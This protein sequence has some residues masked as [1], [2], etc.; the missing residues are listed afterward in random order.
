MTR[1]S[2]GLAVIVSLALAPALMAADD[3]EPGDTSKREAQ[4]YFHSKSLETD[5]EDLRSWLSCLEECCNR[6]NK[7]CEVG[8][9]ILAWL[10]GIR[11]HELPNFIVYLKAPQNDG[12]GSLMAVPPSLIWRK[13]NTP[14]VRGADQIWVLVFSD[15]DPKIELDV[16]LVTLFE[17]T[18]NPFSGLLAALKVAPGTSVPEP[19]RP[20]KTEIKTWT[21]LGP[22]EGDSV[23]YLGTAR[24]PV[25][26]DSVNFL[27][28]VPSAETESNDELARPWPWPEDAE[29]TLVVRPKLPSST[30][31]D[32]NQETKAGGAQSEESLKTDLRLVSGHF[33]NSSASL[34]AFSVGLIGTLNAED[35]ALAEETHFNGYAL[36]K[37]Y[38]RRPRIK[39][40]LEEGRVSLRTRPSLGLVLGTG[41]DDLFEEV[42]VG[43][44]IGH[45]LGRTGVVLGANRIPRVETVDHEW[46]PFVGLE[47]TF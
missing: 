32:D 33:S 1:C 4:R 40:F 20:E 36:A 26:N 46:R 35:T 2:L 31:R 15:R 24:L 30:E 42:V 16:E 9:K 47:Y 22:A 8:D 25:A 37:I 43:V 3:A 7:P 11:R 44:S 14:Y 23:L 6:I 38:V 29:V 13:K 45:V 10:Y 27:S 18:A 12:T 17:K 19:A 39:A 41:L 5:I 34:V 28:L 21:R